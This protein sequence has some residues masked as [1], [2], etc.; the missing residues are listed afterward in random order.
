MATEVTMPKL[1]LTMEQGTILTWK[2]KAGEPI[3]EGEILLVIQTDKVEFDVESPAAGTLL[4]LLA[5]EGDVVPTGD[6]IAYVVEADEKLEDAPAPGGG[7]PA[8]TGNTIESVADPGSLPTGAE[9]APT[10]GRV[11]ASPVARN[12][13]AELGIDLSAVKGSGPGRRIVKEDVLKAVEA[14][15]AAAVQETPHTSVSADR[16]IF[17]SPLARRLARERGIDYSQIRGSGPNDRII[18]NDILQAEQKLEAAPTIVTSPGG[19]LESIPVRGMRQIIAQRMVQSWESIPHVTEVIDVDATKIV[20]MR[21]AHQSVWEEHYGVKIS[22]N[23]IFVHQIARAIRRFPRVNSR[24]N[25]NV[26]EILEEV[27]IGVAVEVDEG[28]MV[29]VVRNADQ[30]NVGQIAG[31][32]RGLAERAR[33]GRI[34]PDELAGGTFTISNLGAYGIQSFTP[35]IDL[36]NSCILGIGKITKTPVVV[37]NE[38]AIRDVVYLSL[39]FDHRIVDGGPA[40]QFLALLKKTLEDPVVVPL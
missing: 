15:S 23:D 8:P 39:S 18:K 9:G 40:A 10:V 21:E 26:I 7:T 29:P 19:I 20:E 25:G 38:V 1:G 27:N 6:V 31:E 22:Y 12:L 13:A 5:N 16:R 35:I 30:K 28:L 24:L 36:P 11:A 2:K 34:N 3:G 32:V 33:E 17:I 37:D 4:R 14:P